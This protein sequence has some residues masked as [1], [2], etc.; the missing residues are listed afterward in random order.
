MSCCESPWAIGFKPDEQQAPKHCHTEAEKLLSSVLRY[1]RLTFSLPTFFDLLNIAIASSLPDRLDPDIAQQIYDLVSNGPL[2]SL[3]FQNAIQS[4]VSGLANPS[5]RVDILHSLAV[6]KDRDEEDNADTAKR[7][8][9]TAMKTAPAARL[10]LTTQLAVLLLPTGVTWE[11]EMMYD[12]DVEVLLSHLNNVEEISG[13][14]GFKKHKKS[15]KGVGPASSEYWT[16][17]IL[18]AAKLRLIRSLEIV[19]RQ[20]KGDRPQGDHLLPR[21]EDKSALTEIRTEIVSYTSHH[22]LS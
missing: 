19:N 4:A 6:D 12:A 18:L 13:D 15:R 20:W 22:N 9:K 8:R 10:A 2:R 21:L 1:H 16:A 3:T 14:I 7:K 5:M 17:D 11:D